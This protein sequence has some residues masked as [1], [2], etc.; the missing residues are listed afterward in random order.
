[1]K[2]FRLPHESML[3]A[4]ERIFSHFKCYMD[5]VESS[6]RDSF[7]EILTKLYDENNLEKIHAFIA[8][9]IKPFL[10]VLKKREIRSRM[11]LI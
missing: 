10:D 2:N 7:I 11:T 8:N 1:M 5:S 9:E 6:K 4:W 3:N